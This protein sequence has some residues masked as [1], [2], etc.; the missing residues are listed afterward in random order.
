MVYLA[1]STDLY[2][3]RLVLVYLAFSTDLCCR[4]LVMVYLASST[5]LCCRRLEWFFLVSS[6]DPVG[7]LVVC[8]LQLYYPASST[9]LVGPSLGAPYDGFLQPPVLAS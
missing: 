1:S 5:D 9:D 7:L 4:R 8:A 2:C 6:T 3:Q